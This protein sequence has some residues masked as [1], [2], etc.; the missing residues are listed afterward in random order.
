MAATGA[1]FTKNPVTGDIDCN[2]PVTENM[3]ASQGGVFVEDH[4]CNVGQSAATAAN[5][6]AAF[7]D[8]IG[9]AMAKDAAAARAA[10]ADAIRALAKI[11]LP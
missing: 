10:A 11:A 9:R 2:S 7:N 1:C 4:P 5:F 8:V 6:S 3:C